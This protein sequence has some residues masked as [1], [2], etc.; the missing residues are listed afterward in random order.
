MEN[1]TM[2]E[3]VLLEGLP[4][5]SQFPFVMLI[6]YNN[7]RGN[8][9]DGPV[10]HNGLEREQLGARA[11]WDQQHRCDRLRAKCDKTYVDGGDKKL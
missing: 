1:K 7:P 10:T 2:D 6:I 8:W 9:W 4:V 11:G 5:P 3:D